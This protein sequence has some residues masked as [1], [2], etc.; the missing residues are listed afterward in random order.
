[1]KR[2]FDRVGEFGEV[3]M[4]RVRGFG[5]CSL[6]GLAPVSNEAYEEWQEDVDGIYHKRGPP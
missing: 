1:V 6:G 5:I 3:C 2:K 4:K